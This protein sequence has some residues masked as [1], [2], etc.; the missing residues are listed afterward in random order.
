MVPPE[1]F[2]LMTQARRSFAEAFVFVL[3]PMQ[4]CEQLVEQFKAG[5]QG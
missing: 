1:I 2:R 3:A 4:A 5:A